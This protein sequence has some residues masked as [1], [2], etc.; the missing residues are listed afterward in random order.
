MYRLIYQSRK[1]GMLENGLLLG[2]FASKY[3]QAM[4]D[5]KKVV[6]GHTVGCDARWRAQMQELCS[7]ANIAYNTLKTHMVLE[8]SRWFRSVSLRAQ[9]VL[10]FWVASR[11]VMTISW[12]VQST[13][14]NASM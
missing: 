4:T 8:S 9:H 2:S 11:T 5:T 6:D 12:C 3:L 7:G 10:C 14:T 13:N 1:R